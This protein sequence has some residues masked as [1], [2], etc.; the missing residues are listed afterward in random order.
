MSTPVEHVVD[1]V[2]RIEAG[3][4]LAEAEL[5]EQY[6]G[7]VRLILLKRTQNP[8]LASDL[9]QDTFVVVLR[10]LRAGDLKNRQSLAAYVRQIAI[11]VSIDHYRKERRYAPQTDGIIS[12]HLS[13]IDH[14][15]DV[16]DEKTLRMGI[17][18][19]L[20]QL[21]VP[22]DREILRRFYLADED[23]QNICRD[24]GLTSSHFDR[25]LY[26]AKKRMRT[27]I[28]QHPR[29]KELLIGGLLDD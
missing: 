17:D 28:N 23:K 8:Q 14:K 2:S 16:I 19:A 18:G 15:S 27:L 13:H 22:R 26:R 20:K 6:A 5:V 7:G 9:C 25:V 24:L 10:K 29:L 4:R 3:D 12:R 11:N 21:A 1:L